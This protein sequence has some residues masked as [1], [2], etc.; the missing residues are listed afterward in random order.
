MSTV[1]ET[2]DNSD[3]LRIAKKRL[4]AAWEYDRE[5]REEALKD[6]RFLAL[7][8]WPEDVRQQREKAGRPCL[9]LD[10]L[11]QY[12]NQVVNDIRQAKIAMKAVAVDNKTD[13]ALADLITE[14]MRD[15]QHQSHAPHVY[16][17]AADGA[18]SCGIGHFRFETD[19]KENAVTEQELLVKHIPYPLAVYWDP[20]SVEPDRSDAMW[21]FV[22]EFIPTLTFEDRYPK[23]KKVDVD[24]QQDYNG[25]GLIWG[26]RDGVL[27]AEYWCKKPVTETL[28]SDDLDEAGEPLHSREATTYKVEQS[29][30][31]G[32]EVLDGPN[33]WAGKHI[34][35]IPIIG[36]EVHLETKTVRMGLIRPARDPQQLYNY[37]RSA[38]AELIA[39]A[40]K[41]KWLATAK[42]IASRL[43]EWANA[44]ISPQAYLQYD[45][46][47]SASGPPQLVPPPQ[48]PEAMWREAALVVDDMKSAVGIYDAALGAKSNETSGVA[49]ARR[50]QEGDVSTYHFADNLSRSL[51]HAGKVMLD[52]IPHIYD[53]QR[54]VRLM[55]EDE[56]Y[57]YEPVNMPAMNDMGMP[58]MINDLSQGRYD[59]RVSIGPSYTTQRLEAADQMLEYFKIDPQAITVSRDIFVKNMEWPGA[60]ELAER[61][62]RTI[63]PQYL[64]PDEQPEQ[65]PDPMAEQ[66]N[67]LAVQKEGAETA[68]TEG[69]ARKAH[70]EADKVELENAVNQQQV[71]QFGV[72]PPDHLIPPTTPQGGSGPQF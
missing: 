33:E 6:L 34:P 37:W 52:L 2:N 36:S 49:I 9:T 67:Q 11:N 64:G 26:N 7:D 47:P 53:T 65:Q 27:V 68:K 29:L 19:Y 4:E 23:A 63:P 54:I 31:T 45:S 50:Q 10:H 72:P 57:R 62:K 55:G 69:E 15:V 38:A 21:C 14:L 25:D 32:A 41:A 16:A 22:V 40:P 13:P 70:A 3:L 28:K 12:K 48:P 42:Q 35:V 43:K 58:I 20:A 5:N 17:K 1:E 51:E 56:E 39:L 24:T 44:H 18:V 30:I 60:D 61:F 59:V 66:I 8:Q 71:Q 46:D